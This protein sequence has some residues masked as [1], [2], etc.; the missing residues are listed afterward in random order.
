MKTL[1]MIVGALAIG[2]V[3]AVGLGLHQT[4]PR[5][6]AFWDGSPNG[7][8]RAVEVGEQFKGCSFKVGYKGRYHQTVWVSKG[9][10]PGKENK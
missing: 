6:Y 9:W 8:C 10:K 7:E 2:V 4:I 5:V 1:A 3:L